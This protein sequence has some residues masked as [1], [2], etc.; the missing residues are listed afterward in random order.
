[1]KSRGAN[2]FRITA[3]FAA[4]SAVG[5]MA[6]DRQTYSLKALF[7]RNEESYVKDY[8]V[9][10]VWS[11]SEAT[12]FKPPVPWDKNWDR[13]V[14]LTRVCSRVWATPVYLKTDG[15]TTGQDGASFPQQAAISSPC[16]R[17]GRTTGRRDVNRTT[18]RQT[19]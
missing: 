18:S 1:M 17:D 6:R 15:T 12:N 5:W 8:G 4:G 7:G 2:L 14:G 3:G 11:L 13:W 16:L 19:N 9:G 10:Q